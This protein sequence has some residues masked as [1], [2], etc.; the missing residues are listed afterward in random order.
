MRRNF[1]Q[2]AEFLQQQFPQLRGHIS[3]A[4][5][6]APPIIELLQRLVSY[7]QL[8]GMAWM[9]LGGETLMRFIGYNGTSRP[10]PQFYWTIQ[11]FSMQI[12]I[13]LFLVIPQFL[14]KYTI[15]GAFEVYLDGEE[16]FS[17]LKSGSMPTADDLMDPLKAAGLKLVESS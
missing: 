5:Y 7:T 1:L 6:P 14:N 15:N 8:I 2:V 12:S 10:L 4:N 11:K 9:I 3:G 17:K 16:I 13:V